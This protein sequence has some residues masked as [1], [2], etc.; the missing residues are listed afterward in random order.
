M[1]RGIRNNNPGNIRKSGDNW[2]GLVPD[3]MQTDKSFFI[4]DNALFGIRALMK[5]LLTY[6]SKYGLNTVR[7][8]IDRWAPPVENDTESYILHV[9]EKLGVL[10]NEEINVYDNLVPLAQAIIKHENGINPYSAATLEDA[11]KLV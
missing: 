4:F 7:G 5:I 2:R 8:I 10:S 6:E 11:K 3:D 9:S 1:V